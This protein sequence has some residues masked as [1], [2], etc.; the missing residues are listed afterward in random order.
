MI[1]HVT[2]AIFLMFIIL[3]GLWS[4]KENISYLGDILW[5]S[6]IFVLLSIILQ[7]TKISHRFLFSFFFCVF[8]ECTQLFHYRWLEYL[9]STPLVYLLGHGTFSFVDIA[10]YFIGILFALFVV[11]KIKSL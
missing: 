1:K 10:S 3:F 6:M 4:S 5:A 7:N 11:L 2:L 9:R 8:I